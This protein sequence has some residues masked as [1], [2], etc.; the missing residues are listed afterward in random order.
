MVSDFSYKWQTF[1]ISYALNVLSGGLFMFIF[2][3]YQ[4]YQNLSWPVVHR[5][6]KWQYDWWD[7][8]VLVFQSM[9]G[10]NGR[11]F[12]AYDDLGNIRAN[13]ANILF[14]H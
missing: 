11:I 10:V 12:I 14:S 3:I 8:P 9:V 6:L 2:Y 1:P 5:R 4:C 13:L 7:G